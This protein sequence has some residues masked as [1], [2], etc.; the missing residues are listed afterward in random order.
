MYDKI[1]YKYKKIKIKKRPPFSYW[2]LPAR[3]LPPWGVRRRQAAGAA[4]HKVSACACKQLRLS[5]SRQFES[6][7]PEAPLPASHEVCGSRSCER[8]CAEAAGQ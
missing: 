3:T 1:H 8:S 4:D 5:G 7:L 2:S 6:T